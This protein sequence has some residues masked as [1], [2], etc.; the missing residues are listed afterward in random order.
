M[1][2]TECLD[3][4]TLPLLLENMR[5][6]YKFCNLQRFCSLSNRVIDTYLALKPQ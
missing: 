3:V 5:L 2:R 4:P 1:T 6:S